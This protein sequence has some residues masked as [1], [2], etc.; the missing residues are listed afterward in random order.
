MSYILIS[1]PSQ[2]LRSNSKTRER[3]L[4]KNSLEPQGSFL[5][6]RKALYQRDPI[7]KIIQ[8]FNQKK[9]NF[10]NNSVDDREGLQESQ[11]KTL[12]YETLLRL[13]HQSSTND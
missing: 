9:R 13:D 11:G 12:E 4:S 3:K 5:V 7:P 6:S 1:S 8:K 2:Q 10:K